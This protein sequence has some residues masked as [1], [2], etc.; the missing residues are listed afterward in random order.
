MKIIFFASL[1]LIISCKDI[2]QDY[3]TISK[4][5]T[6]SVYSKANNFPEDTNWLN[7]KK[8]ISLSDLK[9]K[10]VLIQFLSFSSINSIHAIAD[11]KKIETKYAKELQ[12][13][14]VHSG[15]FPSQKNF[16]NIRQAVLKFDLTYPLALDKDFLF[17]NL[18]GINSWPTHILINPM[19]EIIGKLSGEEIAKSLD[20]VIPELI[21]EFDSKK[22][23]NRNT[24]SF[25][26]LEKD[27]LA[28]TVLSFPNKVILNG[29]GTELF[30]S[31]TN[32]HRILHIDIQNKK[33]LNIIGSNEFGNEDG[34]FADAKF[35]RPNGI[36]LKENILY[37]A[38]T[39]NHS[40]RVADLR[41][42][43]VSTLAGSGKQAKSLN[44][45]GTGNQVS[46]NSPYDLT[47]YK[48]KLYISMLGSH[49]LWT[50]DLKTL[51][52]EVY[53]GSGREN[54]EDGKLLNSALSQP[55]GITKDYTRLYFLDSNTSALRSADLKLEGSIKTLIGKGLFESGDIDG[56]FPDAR[57]QYPVGIFHNERKIF[58]ADTLNHKIKSYDIDTKELRTLAG[59]DDSGFLNS[60]ANESSF[61]E[62][63]SIAKHNHLIY[64]A[65]TNNHSIRILDLKA[66]TVKSFD[67]EL[68]EKLFIKQNQSS[69]KF[70]GEII[71]VPEMSIHPDSTEIKVHFELQP[72]YKWK[73][74][75]P[76]FSQNFSMNESNIA[77]IFPKEEIVRNPILPKIIKI[78]V[79]TGKADLFFNSLLFYSE[80]DSNS[81]TLIK[82]ISVVVPVHV[83]A[84]GIKN[85]KC[86]MK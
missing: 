68:S 76:F 43:K 71:S 72:G 60:N 20:D 25:V 75:S 30:V 8:N 47:E 74:D 83:S 85:T 34:L 33:I 61:N 41:T 37:I 32:H 82:K 17:W 12:I 52:A 16:E 14:A 46:L 73:V 63:S 66:N 18:Y 26:S 1:L 28:E 42:K 65:D 48:N 11:L 51:E 7:T 56:K 54:L 35:G 80:A 5:Q 36:F 40:I 31:D 67:F 78:K 9:G 53:A 6:Q 21:I 55:M 50:L 23:L 29:S 22:K 81:I 70:D 27:K 39:N 44:V 86:R 49:Q 58:I 64:I 84:S 62:P 10:F 59:T 4:N 79:I 2:K 3:P 13:I 77:V 69:K 19:G 45:S 57:L 38:D 24:L 15:K